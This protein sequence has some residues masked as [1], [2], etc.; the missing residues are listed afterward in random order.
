M[1]KFEGKEVPEVLSKTVEGKPRWEWFGERYAQ[2]RAQNPSF[3]FQW[4]QIEGKKLNQHLLS[5]L[6]EMTDKHCSYCDG[7]P[8]KRGD[9]TIDHFHP[10]THPAYYQEVCKWENLYI[11][12]KHCQD[13]KGSQFEIVLL[14][15]DAIDYEFY[16]FFVYDYNSHILIPNP[17]ASEEEKAS[18]E[19]TIRIFDLNHPSMC[20]SRRHA[21][22]RFRKDEEPFLSDY[23][24][25][26]MFDD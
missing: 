10:K 5:D 11:A 21:F 12:C 4:P 24:F 14:R 6:M 2:N 18:A 9:D 26:F 25:R 19:A 15:P 13:S 23:N 16:R 1:R 20:V 17:Q 3:T 22:E 8:L 7:F